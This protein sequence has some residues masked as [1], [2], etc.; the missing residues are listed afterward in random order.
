MTMRHLTAE[1]KKLAKVVNREAA[2][3]HKK[4]RKVSFYQLST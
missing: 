4:W 2:E 1:V 3:D